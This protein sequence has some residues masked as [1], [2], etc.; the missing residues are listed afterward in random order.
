MVYQLDD[1]RFGVWVNSLA[2]RSRQQSQSIEFGLV[3]LPE[4]GEF[5]LEVK[6]FF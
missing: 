4:G 3:S 5:E 6:F 2:S 1:M